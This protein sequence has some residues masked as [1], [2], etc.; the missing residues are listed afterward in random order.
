MKPC[1]MLIEKALKNQ[2]QI[3]GPCRNLISLHGVDD[4]PLKLLTV[5]FAN[6]A[7]NTLRQGSFHETVQVAIQD[8]L[9]VG[10][11][12]VRSQVLDHL[13]GLQNV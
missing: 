5:L 12:D 9:R 11:F 3:F 4:F 6:V 8:A 7:L 10:C 1:L 13:I 2:I